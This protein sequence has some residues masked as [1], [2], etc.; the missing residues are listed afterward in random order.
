M[1]KYA[2]ILE[3]TA[4]GVSSHLITSDK[5]LSSLDEIIINCSDLSPEQENLSQE[6]IEICTEENQVKISEL[7]YHV[8]YEAYDLL[9]F[10]FWE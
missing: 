8:R 5:D 4:S 10:G 6:L 2:V 9:H 1:F 3:M 7:T